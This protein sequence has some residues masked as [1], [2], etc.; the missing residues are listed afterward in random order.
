MSVS[1]IR[2]AVGGEQVLAVAP[3]TGR[4]A[5]GGFRRLVPFTG[6][7]LQ[8]AGLE[9]EQLQRAARL[10]AFGRHSAS[11]VIRG[12]SAALEADRLVIEPGLGLALDGEPV[13]LTRRLGTPLAELPVLA[14]DG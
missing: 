12:L 7:S 13:E 2:D 8:A 6:R 1:P 14:E 11:G 10:A 9:Q 5:D 4:R 3:R